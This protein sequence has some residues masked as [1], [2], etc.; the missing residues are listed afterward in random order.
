MEIK[1]CNTKKK[2][3]CS[4]LSKKISF[5]TILASPHIQ[6]VEGESSL[7]GGLFTLEKSPKIMAVGSLGIST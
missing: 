6:N 3:F 7:I 4:C 5:P 1:G 2:E